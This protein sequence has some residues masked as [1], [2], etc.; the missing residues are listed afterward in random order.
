MPPPTRFLLIGGKG[1]V[2]KTTTAA[3]TALYLARRHPNRRILVFSTDPAHSV[4]DSFGQPVGAEITPIA[5]YGNLWA[6]EIDA[7]QLLE[8][9]R[10]EY[11]RSDVQGPWTGHERQRGGFQDGVANQM[12]DLVPPGLDELMALLEVVDMAEAGEFDVFILDTA[13]TGHLIRFLE[14]PGMAMSWLKSAARMLLK[15]KDTVRLGK[16]AEL[17]VKYSR[18]VR[19]LD[20]QLTDRTQTEFIAVTIPEEMAAVESERLLRH[21][22]RLNITCRQILVNKVTQDSGCRICAARRRREQEHIRRLTDERP[23]LRLAQAP[24]LP[25]HVRGVESLVEFGEMLYRNDGTAE[26]QVP[27]YRLTDPQP[28]I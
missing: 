10:R 4:G 5:P 8:D 24:H 16:M 17:V 26:L 7:T 1:G 18:Q 25:H 6:Y 9:F 14:T 19:K 3:A 12:L 27:R 2:G 13:P 20:Q 21:L 15:Y 22:D 23:A 28:V 11:G